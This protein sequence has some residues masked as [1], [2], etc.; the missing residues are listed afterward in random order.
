MMILGKLVL[1]AYG[2]DKLR[3]DICMCPD[4][5]G[6]GKSHQSESYQVIL[7]ILFLGKELGS[8]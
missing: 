4:G 8:S 3:H 6:N 7:F 5:T 1:I 2:M